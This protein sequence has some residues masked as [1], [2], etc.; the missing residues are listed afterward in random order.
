MG[1]FPRSVKGVEIGVYAPVLAW[2]QVTLMT[3][4]TSLVQCPHQVAD[5]LWIAF[6][7]VIRIIADFCWCRWGIAIQVSDDRQELVFPWERVQAI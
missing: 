7:V 4:A 2:Y 3:M 6:L 1:C 5:Y